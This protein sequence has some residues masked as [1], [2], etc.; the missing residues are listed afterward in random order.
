MKNC[1]IGTFT[2]LE[3]VD[4]DY[5]FF[6]ENIAVF[7]TEEDAGVFLREQ[8]TIDQNGEYVGTYTVNGKIKEGFF[9]IEPS[10]FFSRK[11]T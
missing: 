2:F 3:L 6:K 9:E 10:T 5:H 8:S 7:E 11:A 4:L 1:Y